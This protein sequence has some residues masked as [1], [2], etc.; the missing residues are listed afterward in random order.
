MDHPSEETL[1][2]FA[3][4]T[5]TREEN[6]AVVSHLVKGCQE[7]AWKLRTLME[8]ESVSAGDY[9]AALDSFDQELIETLESSIPRRGL[10]GPKTNREGFS[11]FFSR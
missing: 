7:C 3:A 6:R 8:P 11:S 10:R 9:E 5:A 4:G 1:K 2:R